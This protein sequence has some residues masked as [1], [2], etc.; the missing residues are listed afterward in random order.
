MLIVYEAGS[1]YIFEVHPFDLSLTLK[2]HKVITMAFIQFYH[3]KEYSFTTRF[4]FS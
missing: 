3:K 4:F 2:L 1:P